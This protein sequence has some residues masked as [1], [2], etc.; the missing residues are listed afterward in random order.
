MALPRRGRAVLFSR[1][2]LLRGGGF[3]GLVAVLLSGAV[4]LGASAST[5]RAQG[6]QLTVHPKSQFWIQGEAASIDFTCQVGRVEGRAELPAARDSI[7]R[8]ADQED[9]TEV[10]VTVP[11]E[12]F[13]CGKQRMTRDLQDALKMEDHPEIRFELVHAT[14]GPPLDTLGRWRRV[15]VLGA[16]TIA[17]TK[18]LT[19]LETAGRALDANRF[20]VRGCHPIRMTYF[21][22]DP[23]TKAFGLIRVNN[24]VEV[25]F[26]V[27]AHRSALS[28][29]ATFSSLTVD[30]SPSC[31]V[32]PSAQQEA[33]SR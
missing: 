6:T 12:A 26:D 24:R 16:L 33:A 22:I 2:L 23:P 30:D 18:R 1:A 7:P 14:V 8:S 17:G 29:G 21:N 25:Q 31:P 13:D 28:A 32:V 9:Q 3:A 19:R 27:L 20:R 4:L 10:V 15:D 11:V 5:A